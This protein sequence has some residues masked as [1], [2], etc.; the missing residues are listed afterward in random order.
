M[1]TVLATAVIHDTAERLAAFEAVRT[2]V[3]A[4]GNVKALSTAVAEALRVDV[5]FEPAP[6]ASA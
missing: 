5:T 6:G 4:A 2:D 3:C 1:K